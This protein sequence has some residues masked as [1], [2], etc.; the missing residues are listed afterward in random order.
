MSDRREATRDRL[1][2]AGERVFARS[3]VTGANL[4]EINAEAGLRNNSALHYHFGSREGLLREIASRHQ[5]EIDE[6]RLR[7]LHEL[8]AGGVPVDLERAV[9]ILVRP[10]AAKLDTE[11]GRSYLRIL[12]ELIHRLEGFD[13]LGAADTGAGP[14]PLGGLQRV[15]DAIRRSVPPSTARVIRWRIVEVSH[16]L[17]ASLAARARLLEAPAPPVPEEAHYLEELVAMIAAAL[18]APVPPV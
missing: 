10:M 9:E 5:R 2:R 14:V 17:A 1:L 11:E 8:D 3:G 16:F 4:R 12:P 13:G 6:E 18:R 7:L 15:V